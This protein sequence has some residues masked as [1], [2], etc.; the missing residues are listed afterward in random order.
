MG[1]ETKKKEHPTGSGAPFM[2]VWRVGGCLFFYGYEFL[3]LALAAGT[4]PRIGQVFKLGAGRYSLLGVTFLWV[5]SV[6][7][8]AFHL[9]HSRSQLFGRFPLAAYGRHDGTLLLQF[10]KSLIDLLAVNACDFRNLASVDGCTEL[11]HGL[12][13]LFFHSRLVVSWFCR[14][15]VWGCYFS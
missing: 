6:L 12:Q 7:T 2:M 8:G 10:G 15:V 3:L 1:T 13:Y 9:C 11:T 5:V 14:F 4:A